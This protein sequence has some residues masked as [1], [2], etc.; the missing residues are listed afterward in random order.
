ML[1]QLC[2]QT[3]EFSRETIFVP[4]L[5]QNILLPTFKILIMLRK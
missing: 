1:Y 2:L 4:A 5:Q 3:K